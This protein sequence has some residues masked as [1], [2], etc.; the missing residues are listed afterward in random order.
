MRYTPSCPWPGKPVYTIA[1]W[2]AKREVFLFVAD[3][4]GKHYART[5]LHAPALATN[6]VWDSAK[7][8]LTVKYPSDS[9][10]KR[11][12][13]LLRACVVSWH[14]KWSVHYYVK[15]TACVQGQWLV[16]PLRHR[17]DCDAKTNIEPFDYVFLLLLLFPSIWPWAGF[18][19]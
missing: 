9:R 12:K 17:E 15:R 5:R 14:G 8:A 13:S 6:S 10:H 11:E 19:W 1:L 4:L 3:G 7:V 2:A 18:L 16:R